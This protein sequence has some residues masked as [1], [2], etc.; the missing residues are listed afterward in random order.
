MKKSHTHHWAVLLLH[1]SPHKPQVKPHIPA[2]IERYFWP[3]ERARSSSRA[4]DRSATTTG[5]EYSPKQQRCEWAHKRGSKSR[6]QAR[7]EREDKSGHERA[8]G[9]LYL[10]LYVWNWDSL[11]PSLAIKYVVAWGMPGAVLPF[12]AFSRI[13][14]CLFIILKRLDFLQIRSDDKG[15]GIVASVRF[16]VIEV[17][18]VCAIVSKW[19]TIYVFTGAARRKE[20]MKRDARYQA[21]GAAASSTG[22]YDN[23]SAVSSTQPAS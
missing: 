19:H 10:P 21:A 20:Q 4:T 12:F 2:R 18:M 17:C 16:Y 23:T 7:P 13:P 15:L 1:S 14:M 5:G 6:S 8:I 9:I 22:G 11:Q 3:S